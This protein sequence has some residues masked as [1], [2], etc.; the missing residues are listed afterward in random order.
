MAASTPRNAWYPSGT[1]FPLLASVL[2]PVNLFLI[3]SLIVP[4]P[5]VSFLGFS[6]FSSVLLHCL[7]HCTLIKVLIKLSYF[8]YDGFSACS[9]IE[10]LF[11]FICKL[12]CYLQVCPEPLHELNHTLDKMT[13]VTNSHGSQ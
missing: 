4:W 7:P 3:F 13:R 2:P 9:K 1:L 5:K 6:L 10:T 12:G 11:Y 8:M